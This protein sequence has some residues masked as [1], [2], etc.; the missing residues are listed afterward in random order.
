M[1]ATCHVTSS[2]WCGEGDGAM[3]SLVPATCH[4]T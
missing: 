4:V 1:P 3:I 2:G